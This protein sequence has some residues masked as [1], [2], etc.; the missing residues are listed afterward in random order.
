[1][2]ASPDFLFFLSSEDDMHAFGA[3]LGALLLPGD[4]VSL[5]GDLG[6]GKTTLVRG[7]IRALMSDAEE[8]P[9]PTYTIVQTY[10]VGDLM[11]WHFDLY[12]L[13]APEDVIEIG[14]EEALEDI[15]LIEWPDKAG[16]Y[17]PEDR[18]IIRIEREGD[19]RK[20]RLIPGTSAWET[21]LHEHFSER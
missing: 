1:M 4:I 13:E 3:R 11:I 20:L 2:N 14:F 17:L 10:E 6:A 21:R 7:L 5:E 19:G 9:S 15:C 8:V 12:R 16:R 18:L